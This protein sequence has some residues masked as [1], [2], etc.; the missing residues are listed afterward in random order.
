M[1][2]YVECALK[3]FNHLQPTNHH[4][5][6]TKYKPPE[7]GQK[8]KYTTVDTSPELTETQKNFIQQVCGKFLY[9]GIG[10]IP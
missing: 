2:G 8:I 3:Q 5:G 1:K 4:Y 10:T 9:N 7:S 6:P